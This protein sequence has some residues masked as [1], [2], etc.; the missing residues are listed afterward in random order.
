MKM[1]NEKIILFIGAGFSCDIGLPTMAG[2][3]CESERDYNGIAHLGNKIKPSQEILLKAGDVFKK[4]QKYSSSVG[5][6]MTIDPNNM[7][8]IFCLADII[9]G[10]SLDSAITIPEV[11]NLNIDEI[12][13][14]I[15]LWLWKVFQQCPP[16]NNSKPM[17]QKNAGT[18]EKFFEFI[19][20]QHKD[21][22]NISIITTNYDLIPEFFLNRLSELCTYNI[23]AKYSKEWKAHPDSIRK[24]AHASC[25]DFIPIHKLHGSV[26]YF[27][28][29]TGNQNTVNIVTDRLNDD[30][31]GIGHSHALDFRGNLSLLPLD[32]INELRKLNK[33]KIPIPAIIPP[34]YSKIESMSWLKNIWN[35]ALMAIREAKAIVF[36][37]YSFPQSD[38]FMRSFFQTALANRM[39]SLPPEIINLDVDSSTRC[40]YCKIFKHVK[41]ANFLTGSFIQKSADLIDLINN[42]LKGKSGY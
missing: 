31:D 33:N 9:Q 20:K 41:N 2:F 16:I 11:D 13:E 35:N 30:V 42:Y 5:D 6:L 12:I 24:F 15:R 39:S 27:F 28:D 1:S 22:E 10:T 26:K 7:E 32:V 18:Y 8:D 37:G 36:I 40:R 21:H 29:D 23:H 14:N 3:G 19:V 25:V 17:A 38:G 34:M 4:F